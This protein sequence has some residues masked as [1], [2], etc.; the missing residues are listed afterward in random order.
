MQVEVGG[1]LGAVIEHDRDDDVLVVEFGPARA[2]VTMMMKNVIGPLIL[3]VADRLIL[4]DT[5]TLA[6]RVLSIK[7]VLD[8]LKIPQA[9][10]ED[11]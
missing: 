6:V 8:N 7:D 9:H 11:L 10:L 2:F 3:P 5:R 4:L 1:R